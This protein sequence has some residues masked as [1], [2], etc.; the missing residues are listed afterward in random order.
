MMSDW[1]IDRRPPNEI[2]VEVK[3]GDKIIE[4]MAF[5]GRDGYLPHWQTRDGSCYEQRAFREWRCI[6]KC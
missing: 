2:W 4:A 6:K 1:V 3:D 5:Y